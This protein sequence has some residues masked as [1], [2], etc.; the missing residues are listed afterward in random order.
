MIKIAHGSMIKFEHALNEKNEM[1]TKWL[2]NGKS[3]ILSVAA[4][5]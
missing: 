3:Q 5:Q 4:D 2:S 1:F